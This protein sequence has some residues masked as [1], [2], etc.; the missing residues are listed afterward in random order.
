[1]PLRPGIMRSSTTTSGWSRSTRAATSTPSSAW[2]T[3]RK[4]ASDSSRARTP[5][6]TTGWSSARTKR[7]V[8]VGLAPFLLDRELG[9]DH[10]AAVRAGAQPQPAARRAGPLLHT[11]EPAALAGWDGVD[12]EADPLVGHLDSQDVAG[13]RAV[14][15]GVLDV[16]VAS[17][18]REGLLDDAEGGRLDLW[19]QAPV[20]A[21]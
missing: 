5:S 17:H 7:I 15:G 4:S 14:D 2:P 16:G 13:R 21:R 11:G 3:T 9:D 20:Q 8:T 1:R 12:V 10:G 18:V 6:L 19:R